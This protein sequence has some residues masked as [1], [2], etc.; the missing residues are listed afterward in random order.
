VKFDPEI[1][2]FYKSAIA[3]RRGHDALNHGDYEVVATDDEHDALAFVRRSQKKKL[4]VVLNRSNAKTTL[5]LNFPHDKTTPIFVTKGEVADVQASD[6]GGRLEVK[7][8]PITGAV[9][10]FE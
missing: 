10:T 2:A 6:A 9:L 5:A 8:P 7:L 1:F 3:L 4:L